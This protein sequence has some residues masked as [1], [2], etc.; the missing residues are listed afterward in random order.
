MNDDGFTVGKYILISK[1]AMRSR[2]LDGVVCVVLV[3]R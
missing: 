2:S 3:R 1:K